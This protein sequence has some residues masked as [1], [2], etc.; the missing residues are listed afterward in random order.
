[1]FRAKGRLVPKGIKVGAP[2]PQNKRR[3]GDPDLQW[4]KTVVEEVVTEPVVFERDVGESL[5]AEEDAPTVIQLTTKEALSKASSMQSISLAT[6]SSNSQWS[7]AE[8][9]STPT[10]ATADADLSYC[11]ECY[12]PMHPDPK[13]EKLYIFLH[14]LRYTTTLGCFETPMPEWSKAEWTWEK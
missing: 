7:P 1:M 5:R 2:P 4:E 6:S 12:L 3:R 13:P 9:D 8:P 11:P 14:A 10:Q